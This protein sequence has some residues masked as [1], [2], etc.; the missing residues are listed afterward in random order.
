[1]ASLIFKRASSSLS[2]TYSSLRRWKYDVYLSFRGVDTGP[3]I[4]QLYEELGRKS[5]HIF[6]GDEELQQGEFV[7]SNLVKAIE[8]SQY[9]IVVLS[10]KYT[11][12]K[13]CLDELAKIIECR[14]KT[15]I[16]VLPVFYNADLSNV[17]NQTG[18]FSIAKDDK[19][20]AEKMQIW[21]DAL[22]AVSNLS[23]WHLNQR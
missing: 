23:G 17:R 5:I 9:A 11:D 13:W 20:N 4:D 15:G 12:S 16:T 8:E 18:P 21:K 3:F 2:S 7:T 1:M 6:R 22:R 10:E 19:V 14:E